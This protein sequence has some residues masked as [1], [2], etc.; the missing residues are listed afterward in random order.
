[1]ENIKQKRLGLLEET[2]SYYSENPSERRCKVGTE[3]KYSPTSLGL[4]NSEGC[5]IGRKLSPQKKLE[6][7]INYQ[8]VGSSV[9]SV[10]RE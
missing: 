4:K 5:A 10:F 6:L 3:C 8:N 2:V 9:T 1:M 7:D